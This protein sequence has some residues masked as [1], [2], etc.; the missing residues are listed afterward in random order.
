MKPTCTA[1]AFVLLSVVL[2]APAFGA[3]PPLSEEE[4]KQLASDI[5]QGA[6]QSTTLVDV[7]TD[8]RFER[9]HY[10]S[11]VRVSR[12]EKG[13]LKVGQIIVVQTRSNRWVAKSPSPDGSW[14]QWP[15]LRPCERFFGY[16]KGGVKGEGPFAFLRP[17]GKRQ[18]KYRGKAEL[19]TTKGATTSCPN[20]SKKTKR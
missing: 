8:G 14:H 2:A 6:V 16:L 12:V 20:K 1:L 4:L 3:I 11:K 7:T 9:R 17:N 13:T 5:V 18:R 19:P 10:E 15:S